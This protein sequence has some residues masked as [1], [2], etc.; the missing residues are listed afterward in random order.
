[1][2]AAH[3]GLI[4]SQRHPS[5]LLKMLKLLFFASL[6]AWFASA[7]PAPQSVRV[8]PAIF[9]PFNN[10]SPLSLSVI[11]CITDCYIGHRLQGTCSMA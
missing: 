8:D 10:V 9:Q 1:M 5:F 3:H 7:S 6:G 2:S 4:N 11:L